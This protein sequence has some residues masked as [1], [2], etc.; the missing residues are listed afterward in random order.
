MTE[1]QVTG[2]KKTDSHVD[3][4]ILTTSGSYPSTGTDSVPSHQKVRQQ[5]K[6]A[7]QA[8]GLV[9]T[10][11]WVAKVGGREIDPEKSYID[12]G[13]TGSVRIDFGPREGGGGA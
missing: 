8:L 1:D 3:V 6:K 11:T 2:N 7:A 10:D 5:L 12:N 4:V 9:D 13:L